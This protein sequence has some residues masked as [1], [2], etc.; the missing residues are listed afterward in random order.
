MQPIKNY[1]NRRKQIDKRAVFA[2]DVHIWAITVPEAATS[3][4]VH[5]A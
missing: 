4:L 3:Y 1:I 2:I 5:C